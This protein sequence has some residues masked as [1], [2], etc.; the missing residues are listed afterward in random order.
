MSAIL[1]SIRTTVLGVLVLICS[2][3][4][5]AEVLPAKYQSL[6]GLLCGVLVAFGLIAA[7]DAN[8]S[9]APTPTAT[10]TTVK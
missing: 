2:G 5:Y 6:L 1:S 3:T 10:A 8:K 4:A 9:N 7:K